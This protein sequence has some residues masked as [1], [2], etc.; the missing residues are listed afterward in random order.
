MSKAFGSRLNSRGMARFGI[1]LLC[2]L[3]VLAG[4]VGCSKGIPGS[5][6]MKT[7]K[8]TFAEFKRL[9]LGGSFEVTIE[10]GK[11]EFSATITGDDNLLPMVLTE[12]N[13]EVLTVNFKEPLAPTKRMTLVL[14]MGEMTAATFSG[15]GK[16]VARDLKTN[17]LKLDFS[18]AVEFVG[19]GEVE[20]TYTQLSGAGN[21]D[22]KGLKVR[23]SSVHLSGAANLVVHASDELVAVIS[24]VG[25]VEYYGNPPK[26]S[27]KISGVGK[28]TKME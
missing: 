28:L 14:A 24:G 18:G 16:I 20:N 9:E 13:N 8:R 3:A 15:E 26:V 27:Q 10:T 21:I 23:R 22:L 7:E 11:P 19:T 17:T 4:V 12:V 1:L 2:V 5:G 6:T 25:K